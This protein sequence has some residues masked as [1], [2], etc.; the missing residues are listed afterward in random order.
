MCVYKNRLLGLVKN[1]I[2]NFTLSKFYLFLF[3]FIM[4]NK[5]LE[6][7]GLDLRIFTTGLG[8][9]MILSEI[10]KR[11]GFEKI[12]TASFTNKIIVTFFLFSLVSALLLIFGGEIYEDSLSY[13]TKSLIALYGFQLVSSIVFIQKFH[14]LKFDN[15]KKFLNLSIY[16]SFVFVLYIHISYTYFGSIP[17]LNLEFPYYYE[18]S[19]VNFFLQNIRISGFSV[20]PNYLSLNAII[21]LGL[22]FVGFSNN[23][24]WF[25]A[26][27]LKLI[28]SMYLIMVSGSKTILLLGLIVFVLLC[29]V[30]LKNVEVRWKLAFLIL[31]VAFPLTISILPSLLPID[32][33]TTR[34]SLWNKSLDLWGSNLIFGSGLS[35]FRHYML[36][37]DWIVQ[38]HSTY[39]QVLAENGIIGL[40]LF[41]L[42][43]FRNISTLIKRR[44]IFL[45]T[46]LV[47]FGW[48]FTY[49]TG[50]LPYFVFFN[51]LVIGLVPKKIPSQKVSVI[52]L[53]NGLATGGAEKVVLD[54]AQNLNPLNFDST[55]VITDPT[56]INV[57]SERLNFSSFKTIDISN[58]KHDIVGNNFKL[59]KLLSEDEYNVIHS[60]QITLVYLFI[61]MVLIPD[62][63]FVHTI[64]S[65][66]KR[67][68]GSKIFRFVYHVLFVLFNIEVV[69]ISDYVLEGAKSEY[70]LVS[71]SK[72]SKIYNGSELPSFAK[73]KKFDEATLKI[74]CV[75]RLVE[76]KN[77]HLVLEVA[78]RLKNSG[79]DFMVSIYGEGEQ[80]YILEK[81][82][83]DMNISKYVKFMGVSNDIQSKL[84][85]NHIFL[86]TSLYEGLGLAAIEAM[87]VGLPIVLTNF[88]PA[89]ELA[90]NNFNGF[91]VDDFSAEKIVTKILEIIGGNYSEYSENSIKHSKLF[92]IKTM[93][94]EYQNIYDKSKYD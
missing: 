43:S 75:G 58:K 61:S 94:E 48:S 25:K 50:Y 88:G 57:Y 19:Q 32:T 54:I 8:L 16:V 86:M 24:D 68:F 46:Y 21:L 34:F 33:L 3:V 10:I 47:Y 35:S 69:A 72:L 26:N 4:V 74:V 79:I 71:K 2:S 40:I 49:E 45:F 85:E 55:L 18:G 13:E 67:E 65:D 39:F 22:S 23:R 89:K 31:F 52:N 5:N 12:I 53:T 41:G 42:I 44:S 93:I 82:S 73:V 83:I 29:L 66:A 56:E 7:F 64:H 14:E 90:I 80:R 9:G 11:R 28:I 77:Y 87:S 70:N 81:K 6:L 15:L 59:Y 76:V 92:N 63:A 17:T 62:L 20:D 91:V 36:R 30:Y 78:D 51:L 1:A 84:S 60:H 27:K 37:Y 38:T